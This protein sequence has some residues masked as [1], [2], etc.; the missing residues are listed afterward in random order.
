MHEASAS[1][2]LVKMVEAEALARGEAEGKSFR[3]TRINLVVGEA[4]GY[5]RE[6]LEFYVAASARG[7]RAEGA[8]LGIS[9]VKPLL[10]CPSCGLEYERA[11]FS[12]DCPSCGAQGRM[13]KAGSEFYVDSIEIEESIAETAM[14]ETAKAEA[15]LP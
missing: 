2:A 7:T 9:Y 1:E 15:A 6:S 11:R 12:F 8:S 10:R 3:I 5:M 4:T 14:T 13:T